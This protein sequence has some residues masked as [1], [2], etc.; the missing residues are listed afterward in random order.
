M[1][2]LNTEPRRAA[3]TNV[4]RVSTGFGSIIANDGKY[5]GGQVTVQVKVPDG[6]SK[7]TGDCVFPDTSPDLS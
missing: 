1:N 7:V 5:N 4:Y 6:A 2:D 3:T